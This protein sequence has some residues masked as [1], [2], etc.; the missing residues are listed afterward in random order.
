MTRLIGSD[1]KCAETVGMPQWQ[2][3]GDNMAMVPHPVWL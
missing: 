1:E 2:I 3:Q